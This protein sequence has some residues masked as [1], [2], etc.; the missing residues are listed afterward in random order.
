[1]HYCEITAC[2]T[3][4]TQSYR[5]MY[6]IHPIYIHTVWWS[7]W[8]LYKTFHNKILYRLHLYTPSTLVHYSSN[9][10]QWCIKEQ[11]GST[12]LFINVRHLASVFHFYTAFTQWTHVLYLTSKEN[13][14]S[15][16][17]LAF[18]S[19]MWWDYMGYV[20]LLCLD[21]QHHSSHCGTIIY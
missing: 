11:P 16:A 1:V 19:V 17:L 14:V 9:H 6:H 15:F 18:I 5:T 13:T 8:K 4:S 3:T 20:K 10:S 21:W 7:Y 12:S 2:C